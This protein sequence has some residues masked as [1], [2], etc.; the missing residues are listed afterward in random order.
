MKPSS[1]PRACRTPCTCTSFSTPYRRSKRETLAADPGFCTAGRDRSRDIRFRSGRKRPPRCA[2]SSPTPITPC[3][4][5]AEIVTTCRNLKSRVIDQPPVLNEQTFTG[6]SETGGWVL[7]KVAGAR[8]A[9]DFLPR[10][11][12]YTSSAR[13]NPSAPRACRRWVEIATS[14]PRPS[15]PPSVK[16]VEALT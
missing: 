4:P 3:R 1:S 2:S 14:A 8:A 7:R 9:R 12:I 10:S 11:P 13:A 16:R 6:F 5:T 15:W